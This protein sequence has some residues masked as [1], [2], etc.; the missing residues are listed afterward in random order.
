MSEPPC[1]DCLRRS[2]LVAFL[3]PRLSDALGGYDQRH[4][5][6]LGLPEEDL[7]AAIGGRQADAARRFV[8]SFDPRDVVRAVERSGLTATCRH[9]SAYPGGLLELA[10]PPPVLYHSGDRE[11][12]VRLTSRPTVTVVGA[13]TAS[14]YARTVAYELGRGLA[15]AEVTVVSGLALG[16][17]VVA[18]RGVLDADAEA[19]AVLAG[20]PDVAYP[21][22][23]RAVY[24]RLRAS[25]IV[26]SELPP[27]E[28]PRPWSFPARNRIMA[29]LG[30]LTIVVEAAASSGS[31]ITA[32]FAQQIGRDVGAVPGQVTSR[33][34][35]G[36]N[37]LLR[38]GAAVIRSPQD[39][40]DELLGV[41]SAPLGPDDDSLD[42]SLGAPLAEAASTPTRHR[43]S[44]RE[45]EGKAEHTAERGLPTHVVIQGAPE[46]TPPS[47]SDALDPMLRRLLDLVEQEESVEGIAAEARLSAARV[48]A[49]LG[50]LELMGLVQRH[51]LT[52]YVAAG[53]GAVA[54]SYPPSAALI[55]IPPRRVDHRD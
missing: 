17:D 46:P 53:G 16:V 27:G 48:R 20:G 11:L 12:L 7:I 23:N 2:A 33:L 37:H 26:L 29:A 15:A 35:A 9:D 47:A 3:S 54:S 14:R 24:E 52:G 19:V 21:R 50:R 41:G 1:P 45:R 22:M 34:A 51:G 5:G 13:R 55:G 32:E 18:H 4:A 30:E 42:E 8:A 28:A 40:L 36:V 49:L 25:G 31:L 38:E 43:A 44:A 10:D 6:V 39:A